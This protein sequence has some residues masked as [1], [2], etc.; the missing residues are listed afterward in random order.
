[1]K[2]KFL[3]LFW[4]KFIWIL[5][6]ME[7]LVPEEVR[8]QEKVLREYVKWLWIDESQIKN[9]DLFLVAFMHKSYAADFKVITSHN[10]RLEFLGDSILWACVAKLLF[11]NHPEM[12]ESTMTLYKIALVR[13]E[14]LAEAA[15][16]IWLNKQLFISKWEENNNWREK[17]TILWDA[18]EALLGY[19]YIDFWPDKVLQFVE[20]YL[21]PFM[22]SISTHPVKSYKTLVQELVQ[23]DTKQIPEYR[24]TEA[25]IDEKGNVLLYKSELFINNE[26][27]AEWTWV[28]KKKAQESAAK[29][30]Y[31]KYNK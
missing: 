12:A 31:E 1:M 18:F 3:R 8:K 14:T 30:Y 10:E 2:F 6:Q 26:K 25:E 27:N 17:E 7:L 19:L 9:V 22:D 11:I 16:K 15:K 29:N 28:N 23:R 21:Y 24:E 13:E 5:F 20:K 4:N